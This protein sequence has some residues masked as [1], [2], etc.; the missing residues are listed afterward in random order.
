MPRYRTKKAKKRSNSD[1]DS[2]TEDEFRYTIKVENQPPVPTE[3]AFLELF[4]FYGSLLTSD[5]GAEKI[6]S[7]ALSTET[8]NKAR[9]I[10]VATLSQIFSK[11]EEV[12][13]NKRILGILCSTYENI[14]NQ[15]YDAPP[16]EVIKTKHLLIKHIRE[17]SHYKWL[18]DSAIKKLEVLFEKDDPLKK[19]LPESYEDRAIGE[20]NLEIDEQN[21]KW[22]DLKNSY[23]NLCGNNDGIDST[24]T[25][26]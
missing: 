25:N 1:S 21:Q 26:I 11:S 18:K 15:N 14:L 19:I 9:L 23:Y 8:S 24:D 10:L 7:I 12:A 16:I 17:A 4:S 3:Y 13:K 20:L 6:L 2:D 22:E 5:S